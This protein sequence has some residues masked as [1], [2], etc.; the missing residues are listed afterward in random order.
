VDDIGTAPNFYLRYMNV[1]LGIGFVNISE[2]C[3][4]VRIYSIFNYFF[5]TFSLKK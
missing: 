1:S 5:V 2:I 3:F 4:F